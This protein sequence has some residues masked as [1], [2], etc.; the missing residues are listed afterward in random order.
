[1]TKGL[2]W[3]VGWLVTG[4]A[5]PAAPPSVA[6]VLTAIDRAYDL[7]GP[8]GFTLAECAAG[9]IM[10][11]VPA[12]EVARLFGSGEFPPPR[13]L[14][15][16][17]VIEYHPVLGIRF[18][19]GHAVTM[20]IQGPQRVRFLTAGGHTTVDRGAR[21]G[22][23]SSL[24]ADLENALFGQMLPPR[25]PRFVRLRVGPVES[26][27]VEAM[28]GGVLRLTSGLDGSTVDVD[29]RDWTVVG[30]VDRSHASIEAEGR[31]LEWHTR[32]PFRARFPKTTLGML[33]WPGRKGVPTA[34]TYVTYTEPKTLPG[35][36]PARFE[37][38][39]L[40]PVAVDQRTG[41]R[42][43]PGDALLP[44]SE[45]P[46]RDAAPRPLRDADAP[47]FIETPVKPGDPV[48]PRRRD[49]ARHWLLGAGVGC[50][51]LGLALWIRRAI[52]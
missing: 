44:S 37:W 1:M 3:F 20:P 45:N 32:S 4:G 22:R 51:S 29:P 43:G 13:S 25:L 14:G 38:W 21:E 2:A 46:A 23:R 50:L 52:R 15:D 18:E 49:T 5:A 30:W 26:A 42:F 36:E 11:P 31:V 35:V 47:M 40:V 33:R 9:Q 24:A 27:R 39:S 34:P 10:Q 16:H 7:V 6:E 48:L 19:E 41:A 28:E 12:A 17:R 8:I